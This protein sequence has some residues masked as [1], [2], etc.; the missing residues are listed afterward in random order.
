MR[1]L[2]VGTFDLFHVGHLNMIQQA[3]RLGELH[4]GVNTD[5]F[6]ATYKRVPVIPEDHRVRIVKAIRDVHAVYLND[7]P[8][9]DLIE[10]V[11]PHVVVTDTDW[12]RSRRYLDQIGVDEDWLEEHG[13]GIAYLPRTPGVSTSDLLARC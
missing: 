8:G 13:V 2:L 7:G 9:R 3:A 1:A 6:A 12:H 10:K 4:V 11:A 5:R